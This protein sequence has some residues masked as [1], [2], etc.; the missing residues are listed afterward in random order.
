M[1]GARPT[2]GDPILHEIAHTL[3]I[4]V[5]QGHNRALNVNLDKRRVLA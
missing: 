5:V 4:V 3:Y 1:E 2:E